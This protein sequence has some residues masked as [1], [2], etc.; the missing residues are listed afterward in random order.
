MKRASPYR[1]HKGPSQN[2][3]GIPLP[4]SGLAHMGKVKIGT[5]AHE[6]VSIV[7]EITIIA[8]RKALISLKK[9]LL[10]HEKRCQLH[11][12]KVAKVLIAKRC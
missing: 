4:S 2:P 8:R 10:A 5:S 7:W 1:T 11:S 9:V 3:G 12:Q 6:K